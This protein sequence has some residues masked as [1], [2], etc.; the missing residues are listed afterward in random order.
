[1]KVINEMGESTKY[2]N[3]NIKMLFNINKETNFKVLSEKKLL[4]TTQIN[5]KFPLKW[6]IENPTKEALNYFKINFKEV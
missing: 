6:I 2:K 3:E 1:M 4:I 5:N